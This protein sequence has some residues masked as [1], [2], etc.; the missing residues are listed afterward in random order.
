MG[1][2][3]VHLALEGGVDLGRLVGLLQLEDQ[4]HQRLGDEAAAE[5][6]EMAALVRPVAEGIGLRRGSCLTCHSLAAAGRGGARRA[7]EGADLLGV[8]VAGRP[9]D[10]GR[11]VDPARP[12][13]AHGLGDI[14]GVETA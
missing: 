4:R 14:A 7:D 13:D 9:F 3:V 10:A 8:L 12:G 2:I 11:H 1:E 6:A 5:H